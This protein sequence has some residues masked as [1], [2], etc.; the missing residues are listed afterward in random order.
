MIYKVCEQVAS[1]IF[2]EEVVVVDLAQ[3]NYYSIQG[4]GK[5]L[6]DLLQGG[7]DFS[8]FKQ[9]I[10]ARYAVD[11]GLADLFEQHI[12]ILKT[13]NLIEDIQPVDAKSIDARTDWPDNLTE[14]SIEV[15]KD[16]QDL[17]LLDP[18]HQSPPVHP[19]DA[20]AHQKEGSEQVK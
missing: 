20:A 12:N 3:G 1:D 5:Y 6:W 7:L 11:R 9:E 17:L 14:P 15:Y 13:E 16:L 8:T 18:I 4:G 10:L 19:A 2:D